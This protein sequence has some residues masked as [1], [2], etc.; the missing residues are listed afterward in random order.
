M[1]RSRL[2]RQRLRAQ[3]LLTP[4]GQEGGLV[5]RLNAAP[6]FAQLRFGGTA[7]TLWRLT[8]V[9]IVDIGGPVSVSAD[10]RGTLGNPQISGQ[11]ATDN[12]TIAHSVTHTNNAYTCTHTD[13][14]ASGLC[15]GVVGMW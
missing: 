4:L 11:L 6:L 15:W 1:R 10:M 9:E 13:H 2:A 5:S 8:G 14:D 12:A 3:A 7:D